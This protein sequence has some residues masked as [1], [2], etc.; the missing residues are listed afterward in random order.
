VTAI[1][2]AKASDRFLRR[3]REPYIVTGDFLARQVQNGDPDRTTGRNI[4]RQ[5]IA[6]ENKG[7]GYEA[8]G[9]VA[10]VE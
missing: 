7:T 3:V 4:Q 6:F 2:D 8:S 9:L 5:F 1:G 10:G